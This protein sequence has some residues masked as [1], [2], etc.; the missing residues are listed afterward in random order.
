MI[1]K[2]VV[3]HYFLNLLLNFGLDVEGVE[4]GKAQAPKLEDE[5][6]GKKIPL[7]KRLGNRVEVK[8]TC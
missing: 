7:R 4:I 5:Q 6:G 3:S 8:A 1:Q 2:Y